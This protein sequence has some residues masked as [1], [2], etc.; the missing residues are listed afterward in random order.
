MGSTW[1]KHKYIA[2]ENGRYI[3]PGDEKKGK[4]L[5]QDDYKYLKER[6]RKLKRR[7]RRFESEIDDDALGDKEKMQRAYNAGDKL[8]LTLERM[9]RVRNRLKKNRMAYKQTFGNKIKDDLNPK[10]KSTIKNANQALAKQEKLKKQVAALENQR[11]EYNAHLKTS[12]KTANTFYKKSEI[13]KKNKNDESYQINGIIG[14]KYE[15]EGIRYAHKLNVADRRI[16]ELNDRIKKI[17]DKWLKEKIALKTTIGRK[18][19]TRK[20]KR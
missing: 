4:R 13:G 8:D 19:M 5:A 16:N 17:G 10:K 2:I 12:K 15:S 20:A 18:S 11:K 14:K 6:M 3:Y 1:K 9:E 7:Q